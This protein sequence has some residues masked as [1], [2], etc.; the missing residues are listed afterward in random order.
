M[1]MKYQIFSLIALLV[2][3]VIT[4]ISANPD[5][6][7]DG[8]AFDIIHE[9]PSVTISRGDSSN[10]L[11]RTFS[12]EFH[13]PSSVEYQG[14]TYE[15]IGIEDAGF[16]GCTEIC[17]LV[18][19][20]GVEFIGENAFA[21][22]VN[23]QSVEIPASVRSVDGLAFWGCRNLSSI[24][25]DAQNAFLD[26]RGNCNGII[27]SELDELVVTCITTTIPSTVKSIGQG[28]FNNR[29]DIH[30]LVIPEGVRNIGSFAFAGCIN[31]KYITLPMSLEVIGECAFSGCKSLKSLYVPKNVRQLDG[32]KMFSGCDSLKSV[33]V[34]K[35]N[36]YYD[37][38]EKCN[39]IIE[40]KDSKLIAGCA[41]SRLMEGLKDI[42]EHAFA[43]TGIREIDMPQ[44]LTSFSVNAFYD[45]DFLS[46]LTAHKD[47]PRYYVPSGSN[48]V[49]RKDSAILV[50]G[51]IGT[52]LPKWLKII[53]KDAFLGRPVDQSILDLP[54][55]LEEIREGA[56]CLCDNLFEV[57]IPPS[58]TSIGMSAF[59]RCPQLTVVRM[60]G[61][62]KGL[63]EFMFAECGNL[64][65][66]D[67]PEGIL[68]VRSW[69]FYKC[70]N[71]R[72]IVLPLSVTSIGKNA[73]YGCPCEEGVKKLKL[74]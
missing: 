59:S 13:I 68:D 34:D 72:H 58:V 44:S 26:S 15:V 20:E 28:A 46:K 36:P 6:Y 1:T 39:A 19:E 74:H 73:F 9:G 53:G 12:G 43:G 31:L 38:R 66:V 21:S 60:S 65:V 50:L 29:S 64:A 41:V 10:V 67:L 57:R 69:A 27:D 42:G 55:G 52:V 35:E 62:V 24:K 7:K 71:L 63:A 48:A 61:N 30:E 2:L 49:I 45:C 51:C 5:F 70:A 14:C 54:N 4:P 56:F 47:N 33:M 40:T 8:F 17:H 32:R 25:V 37:S 3:G 18:V 23:L 11:Q 16:Y 22:C